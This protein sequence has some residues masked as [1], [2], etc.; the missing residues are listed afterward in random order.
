MISIHKDY[1]LDLS[2]VRGK[3]EER[4]ETYASVL[5]MSTVR[6]DEEMHQNELQSS[7]LCNKA[8]NSVLEVR[9]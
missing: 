8:G 6:H 7:L 3:S 1:L 4:K 9:Q 2:A 5:R